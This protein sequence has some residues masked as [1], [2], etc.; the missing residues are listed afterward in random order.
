[1]ELKQ[2]HATFFHSIAQ[3]RSLKGDALDID[4]LVEVI[5]NNARLPEGSLKFFIS[6]F[7][8]C[9]HGTINPSEIRD[10]ATELFVGS[11]SNEIIGSLNRDKCLGYTNEEIEN[12]RLI[13][14]SPEAT[15]FRTVAL[16][17][18]ALGCKISK[19]PSRHY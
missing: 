10:L 2:S 13:L 7:V 12:I 11:K 16:L 19:D 5:L 15:N 8:L 1:M 18:E 3:F 9:N 14:R 17:Q 6:K 4:K